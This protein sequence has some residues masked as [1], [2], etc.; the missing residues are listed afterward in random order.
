MLRLQASCILPT[1]C[2]VLRRV[3]AAAQK[4]ELQSE[5]DGLYDAICATL[6]AETA[7]SQV[8]SRQQLTR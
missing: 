1:L 3:A 2:A 5:V 8:L 7:D 6:Q 4:A